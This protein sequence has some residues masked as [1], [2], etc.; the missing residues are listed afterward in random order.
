[1][2]IHAHQAGNEKAAPFRVKRKGRLLMFHLWVP[3]IFTP[4]NYLLGYV[5][6]VEWRRNFMDSASTTLNH[7][8]ASPPQSANQVLYLREAATMCELSLPFDSLSFLSLYF[9]GFYPFRGKNLF[10]KPR[11]AIQILWKMQA[12]KYYKIF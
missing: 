9:I 6:L 5:P 2:F 3:S 1:M 4:C 8:L 12:R 11:E 7:L 10:E